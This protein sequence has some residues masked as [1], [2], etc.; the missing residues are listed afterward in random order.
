MDSQ[1]KYY[2]ELSKKIYRYIYSHPRIFILFLSF[3]IFWPWVFSTTPI[4]SGDWGYGFKPAM[5]DGLNF[6]M[7]W[8]TLGVGHIIETPTRY[9][10]E[11]FF[12]SLNF[13]PYGLIQRIIYFWPLVF[14]SLLA[15][16]ELLRFVLRKNIADEKVNYYAFIGS[17][18]YTLNTYSL[19]YFAGQAGLAVATTFAPLFVLA[20]MKMLDDYQRNN[21]VRDLIIFIFAS[22]V[23]S[24][25]EFRIFYISCIVFG[26]YA[27][28]NIL[29]NYPIK[30]ILR[31]L[32]LIFFWISG[33]LLL[34]AF[35]LIGFIQL[36]AISDNVLSGRQLFGSQFQ[37]L[38]Y[39][40]T[41]FDTLW[42]GSYLVAFRMHRIPL[43]S[44]IFPILT[45]T[46]FFF[47]S[48]ELKNLYFW[49]FISFLGIILTTQTNLPIPYLYVWLYD[50]LPGFGYFRE[51]SKFYFMIA[52]GYSVL[53]PTAIYK[54]SQIR[55]SH[56]SKI[57]AVSLSASV[58]IISLIN[59]KP[60]FLNTV[61][62]LFGS[63]KLPQ[64]YR[65]FS[66]LIFSEKKFFRTLGVPVYSRWTPYDYMHPML[67]TLS[68]IAGSV[69]D[70][71]G[72]QLVGPLGI[73]PITSGATP[74][75]YIDV[76]SRPFSKSVFSLLSTKYIY[77]PI[78]DI[79]ND[80][81]FFKDYQKPRVRHWLIQQLDNIQWLRKINTDTS[82][83]VVYVNVGYKEV[84]HVFT[85]LYNFDSIDN[86][87]EKY[88][89]IKN[90]FNDDDAYFTV[91]DGIKSVKNQVR[92]IAPFELTGASDIT[93]NQ[94]LVISNFKLDGNLPDLSLFVKQS[95]DIL[96]TH[97]KIKNSGFLFDEERLDTFDASSSAAG[98][99]KYVLGD[100]PVGVHSVK[101]ADNSFNAD[102]LVN[103]PSFEDG[104][105][106][107]EVIDCYNYD[108]NPKIGMELSRDEFSQ[109]LA[110]LKLNA[111]R[112]AA[113][114]T[115]KIPI[116]SLSTYLFRFD[117]K[118]A[119]KFDVKYSLQF[120]DKSRTNLDLNVRSP[121]SGWNSNY[122]YIKPPVGADN[123]T[124]SLKAASPDEFN[125]AVFY[126]DNI[127][128]VEVPDLQSS[129]FFAADGGKRL[130][131]P[132][133][134]TY[135]MVDPTKKLVHI[136]G[137]SGP[138]FLAFG[139]S[140]HSNWRLQ[141][142]NEKVNGLFRSWIPWVNP[143][144]ISEIYHYK[145]DDFLNAWY[146]DTDK[147]CKESSL[148]KLNDD[149]SYDIEMSIEFTSQRWFY[150]GTIIT[151]IV[152][153]GGLLSLVLYFF[154]N[155][156][157]KL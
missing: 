136:K 73:R 132:K 99:R 49:A 6:P 40:I 12:R 138:F 14:F 107:S 139:E 110:S 57:I 133:A 54:I 149:G 5:L 144:S 24:S 112:H 85:K 63:Y 154:K 82:E 155:K 92:V 20:G 32:S 119:K 118:S 150:V 58:I 61:K 60:I 65:V 157:R 16:F 46:P 95:D 76:L 38:S 27:L 100:L 17:F 31:Y 2:M 98:F 88:S 120:D 77:V 47:K 33:F 11:L 35:W 108:N 151:V 43:Y 148:C 124:I 128:F 121:D 103:N 156:W 39:V 142:N 25:L 53:I 114:A 36:G 141:F 21:A 51:S 10:I 8:N 18:V 129:V 75:Q 66:D 4:C 37:N 140:Y 83:L 90:Q 97:L 116:T 71:Q 81:D 34:N 80:D 9:V 3:V 78:Q 7:S 143:N 125:E 106:N 45:F 74:E 15:P 87:D 50:H 102:N 69:I 126:F 146:V 70:P 56:I 44:W 96:S 41:L 131:K 13:F 1:R 67:S 152:F 84:I 117:Y 123:V 52:M 122:S 137:A 59:S 26:I 94:G 42:S 130:V 109:G 48:K 147:Y 23:L 30:N 101:Y 29:I 72:G 79:A 145:L 62:G 115:T 153:I 111:K 113:C 64:D 68:L 89:L 28:Y 127:S 91:N 22:F 105:W 55:F 93:F 19:T 104:L 135:E 134:V 86:F